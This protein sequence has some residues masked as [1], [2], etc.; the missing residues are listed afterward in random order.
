MKRAW[1][2]MVSGVLLSAGSAAALVLFWFVGVPG[3]QSQAPELDPRQSF[4]GLWKQRERLLKIGLWTHDDGWRVG[5]FG[6]KE[7]A[8]PLIDSLL[9][10][11]EFGCSNGH[12]EVGICYIAN[13]EPTENEKLGAN[14]LKWWNEHKDESQEQWICDGFAA[15]GVVVAL[16]PDP[17]D[18]DAL[19]K[20]LGA[21]PGPMP[22]GYRYH[23][24]LYPE[25]ARYNAYRW[26][27][28]S[29]F[30]PVQYLIGRLDHS[31]DLTVR[32]G[33]E[34]YQRRVAGFQT[35]LPGKLSFAP[36]FEGWGF[37]PSR[38]PLALRGGPQA[39]FTLVTVAATLCG[40]WLLR[41]G[42]RRRRALS[43]QA[44]VTNAS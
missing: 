35:E 2:L 22:P 13:R 34:A 18:W 4:V 25:S 24:K 19:L 8:K 40:I 9:S 33:I 26:L 41:L 38:V 3:L 7:W 31:L 37:S 23:R 10:A 20:V 15:L 5:E 43:Q 21:E 16:P 17:K 1:I 39:V 29:G 28:D 27:R 14:W 42:S 32:L 44:L 6:G 11:K 36:P 30:D 12:P